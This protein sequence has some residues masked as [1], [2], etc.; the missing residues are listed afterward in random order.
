MSWMWF[1]VDHGFH[2]CEFHLKLII[3]NRSIVY[4]GIWINHGMCIICIRGLYR[5]P[6]ALKSLESRLASILAIFL[7]LIPPDS[8]G[9]KA[10]ALA[11]AA[12]WLWPQGE[13]L[14]KKDFLFAEVDSE[15]LCCTLT[16]S[17]VRSHSQKKATHAQLVR[18]RFRLMKG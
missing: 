5:F 12:R 17:P 9:L 4:I 3:F 15:D 2:R 6:I 18:G 10:V 8:W 1:I 16:R 7:Q 11:T 14:Q 13:R